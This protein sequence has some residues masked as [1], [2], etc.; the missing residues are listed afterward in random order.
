MITLFIDTSSTDVSIALIKD[1]NILSQITKS[2][3]NQHSIYTTSYIDQVLKNTNLTPQDVNKIMVV[4]GPGSFT[5][6]RIGVTIAKVFAYIQNIDI[7][8]LSSLKIR[9]ISI[10]HDLCLSLMKANRY[11]YYLGLYD[12]DNSPIIEEHFAN[13]EEVIAIIKKYNPLIVSSDNLTI[14]DLKVEKTPLNITAITKYYN[15]YK[16]SNP[17]LVVPNYLKLP[18]ALE[19]QNDQRNN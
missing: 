10:Q 19:S 12:K 17:H 8:C 18:Q 3:P 14:D 5:G 7:I 11:N 16:T 1:N 2:I 9:A 13:K 15:H 6:V 4:N